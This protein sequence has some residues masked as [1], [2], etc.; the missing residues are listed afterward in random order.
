M[1]NLGRT[2]FCVTVPL[3][4]PVRGEVRGAG[5]LCPNRLSAIVVCGL[6]LRAARDIQY[7]YVEET[8][9]RWVRRSMLQL[10]VPAFGGAMTRLE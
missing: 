2:S 9:Q 1:T 8:L 4:R 3:P 6:P 5:S 10:A 7:L